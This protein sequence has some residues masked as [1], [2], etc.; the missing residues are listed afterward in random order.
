[1]TGGKLDSIP[2]RLETLLA[3]DRDLAKVL[4]KEALDQILQAEM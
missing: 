2:S 3:Q 1:M 4:L